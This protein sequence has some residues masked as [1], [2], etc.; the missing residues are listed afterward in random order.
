LEIVTVVTL[1]INA[2]RTWKFEAL[3]QRSHH[4]SKVDTWVYYCTLCDEVLLVAR[5]FIEPKGVQT[6]FDGVCPDCGFGLEDVM[7]CE[8]IQLSN[9]RATYVNPKYPKATLLVEQ[10]LRAFDGIRP[11]SARLTA[12]E[13]QIFTTGIERLDKLIQLVTGQFIV[14]QG[15][16]PSVSLAELLCVRAQLGKPIGLNSSAIFIDGGNSFDAY[17]ASNYAIEYGIE[18][19][20]ALSRIHISRAFTYFQLVSLLTENL[21]SALTHYSS[22]FAIVSDITE[23]FQDPEVKD[24]QEA[25]RVFQR[26]LRSLPVIAEITGS[27]VIATSFGQDF[28]PFDTALTQTAHATIHVEE[29]DTFMR[30]VLL[31]HRSLPFRETLHREAC[32]DEFLEDFM[33]DEEWEESSHLGGSS[34]IKNLQN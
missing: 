4:A 26:M 16:S 31:R 33:E 1:R 20:R 25:Y 18:P 27:L 12:G 29:H 13:Q 22:K 3:T 5:R 9:A 17:A 34:S 21:P 2:T 30:F 8:H 32:D 11:R 24:K 15:P 14:F 7:N 28:R 10:P 6:A 19:N 23:L